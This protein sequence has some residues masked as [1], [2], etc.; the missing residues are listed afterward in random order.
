M[1]ELGVTLRSRT[2]CM[3]DERHPL[4]RDELR[5]LL[6]VPADRLVV[7]GGHRAHTVGNARD[8]VKI[9]KELWNTE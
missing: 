2:K 6:E 1:L 7:V 9:P 5:G 3:D 4:L 8:Q